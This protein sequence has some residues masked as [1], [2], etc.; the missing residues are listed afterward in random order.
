MNGK[1]EHP[2]SQGGDFPI[3]PIQGTKIFQKLNGAAHRIGVR[4][5]DP[6]EAVKICHPGGFQIEQDFGKIETFDFRKIL[7]PP[8]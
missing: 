2:V 3:L 6:A 4:H 8:A 5:F 1:R 7:R